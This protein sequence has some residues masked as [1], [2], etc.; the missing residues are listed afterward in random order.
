MVGERAS[1]ARVCAGTG[2][3]AGVKKNDNN[4]S[5]NKKT[6]KAP[7]KVMSLSKNSF[8][9]WYKS[10][11]KP[12]KKKSNKKS[13]KNLLKEIKKEIKKNLKKNKLIQMNQ[14]FFLYYYIKNGCHSFN[15]KS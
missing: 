8:N 10:Q 5:N 12:G 1:C 2:S 4:I 15:E 14:I 7:I 3:S 11:M 6:S 13:I 9:K